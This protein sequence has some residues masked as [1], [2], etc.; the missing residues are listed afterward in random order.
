MSKV[1]LIYSKMNKK[2]TIVDVVII[3]IFKVN[4]REI[5][6]CDRVVLATNK[7]LKMKSST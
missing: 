2:V 7:D 5:S 4:F 3:Y 6:L 1:V